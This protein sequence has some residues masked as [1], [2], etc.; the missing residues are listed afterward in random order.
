MAMFIRVAGAFIRV[1]GAFMRV[2]GAFARDTGA[3]AWPNAA[4]AVACP[5]SELRAAGA[6]PDSKRGELNILEKVTGAC[7]IPREKAKFSRFGA[8]GSAP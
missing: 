6:L 2:A 4:W 8:I 1:A 5:V 7:T 3:F